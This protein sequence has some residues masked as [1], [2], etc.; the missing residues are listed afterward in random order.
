MKKILFV[1][2]ILLVTAVFAQAQD[3]KKSNLESQ[4]S[5]LEAAADD[6][7][8]EPLE[9]LMAADEDENIKVKTTFYRKTVCAKSGKVSWEE[10]EYCSKSKGFKSVA[11]KDKATCTKG[12]KKCAKSKKCSKSKKA[13]CKKG[14]KK[15]SASK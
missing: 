7:A 6:L 13:C 2:S 4:E 10:V 8:D 15:A 12:E 5:I 3:M 1:F 9:A 11:G 14:A